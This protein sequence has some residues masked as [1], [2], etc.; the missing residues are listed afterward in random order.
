[1]RRFLLL[2][3][4]M[5]CSRHEPPTW[6]AAPG[7]LSATPLPVSSTPALPPPTADA[8][9]VEAG[10]DVAT[11]PQTRDRPQPTG[12]TFDGH[13]QALWDGIVKDDPTL[14]MPFFFPLG[15]YAQVKA[16]PSPEGDWRR[17]LVANFTRDVHKL[18]ERL[19]DQAEDARFV[20][21][22]VPNERVRWIEPGEEGNKLGYFRVYGTKLRYSVDGRLAAF[23][24]SSLISWRGEWY[25]VHLSGFK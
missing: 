8:A 13:V 24:V 20:S 22:E 19:G 16:I 12:A 11:L 5:R 15:A 21:L 10:P 2:A 18:H 3:L 23:D 7:S 14:A 1:M 4:L 9:T 25:V 17:R 6:D